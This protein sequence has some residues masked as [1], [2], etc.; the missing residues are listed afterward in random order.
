[1]RIVVV[2]ATGTI[3]SAVVRALARSGKHEVIGVSRHGDP[4]LDIEDP[5]AVAAFF[6][7]VGSLDAV[8]SCAGGAVFKPLAQLTDEDFER[9]LKSKLLGQVGLA[10]ALLQQAAGHDSSGSH[11]SGSHSSENG[12]AENGSITLTS[13][14][15]AQ[16]P[17]RGSAAISLVNAALEGFVRA[18]ALEAPR[19]IRVNVVSPPWVTETLEKLG[20]EL[21]AGL[22]ADTVANAYVA[23]VEGKFQGQTLNPV[24]FV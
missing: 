6:R 16:R 22:P 19:G 24:Q 5:G 21:S 3:G 18:A 9:S 8:I 2:G 20:M 1:M 4:A 23:A 14:I 10:R 7:R 13:G 15:L 11:S 12:L 17:M